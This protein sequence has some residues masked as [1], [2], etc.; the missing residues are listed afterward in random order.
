MVACSKIEL[1][2][3]DDKP[4]NST[5]KAG[6]AISTVL[7]YDVSLDDI[8][9]YLID[10]QNNN[11]DRG[12]SLEAKRIEQVIGSSGIVTSYIINYH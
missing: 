3:V 5:T 12:I 8:E 1:P 10:R 7:E 4:L 11:I 9:D 6:S 2:R